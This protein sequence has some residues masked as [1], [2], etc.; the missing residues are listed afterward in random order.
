[1]TVVTTSTILAP[2]VEIF[3]GCL[4]GGHKIAIN[5]WWFNVSHYLAISTMIFDIYIHIHR[6]EN[7]LY[8]KTIVI[9]HI[10]HSLMIKP[11]VIFHTFH[12]VIISKKIMMIGES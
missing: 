10:F 4:S 11:I 7:F 12:I 9:F 5:Y 3:N 2:V 8:D 6:H 1:M